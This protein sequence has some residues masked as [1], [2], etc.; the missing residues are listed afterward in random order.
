MVHTDACLTNYDEIIYTTNTLL[1][2]PV[3]GNVPLISYQQPI[4]AQVKG[5]VNLHYSK[6][7]TTIV[8]FTSN[9]LTLKVFQSFPP[10]LIVKFIPF[11]Y[12]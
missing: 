5:S 6:R 7:S 2:C 3:P 12:W 1:L 10:K 8:S 11:F 4:Q 9:I